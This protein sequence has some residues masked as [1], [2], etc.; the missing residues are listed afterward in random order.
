MPIAKLPKKPQT[1]EKSERDLEAFINGAPDGRTTRKVRGKTKKSVLI[2]LTVDPEMLA[3]FDAIAESEGVSR[4]SGIKILL[5]RAVAK[6]TL[7]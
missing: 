4:A 1:T 7:F 2:T 3:A 5:K 6:G